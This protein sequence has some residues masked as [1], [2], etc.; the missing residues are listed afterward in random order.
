MT[1]LSTLFSVIAALIP[2]FIGGDSLS[3]GLL[4]LFAPVLLIV[5]VVISLTQKKEQSKL[6]REI[7]AEL[8]ALNNKS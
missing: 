6:L 8:K 3:L 7:V 4:F 2:G 1:L 5:Y